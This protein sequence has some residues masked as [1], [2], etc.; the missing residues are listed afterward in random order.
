MSEFPAGGGG[1]TRGP[2]AIQQSPIRS[3]PFDDVHAALYTVGQ[4]CGMLGVQP[5]FLRRLDAE[6]IVSPARSDGRHR[7]YSR[8]QILDVE[9]VLSL[10]GDGLT[11][12]GVRRVLLLEAQVRGLERQISEM[13]DEQS[14]ST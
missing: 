1:P 8:Q 9:H 10:T 6:E 3:L 5:A 12:A 2:D 7:Q 4:V 14:E 13:S 11:L